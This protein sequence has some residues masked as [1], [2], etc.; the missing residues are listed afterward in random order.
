MR[1]HRLAIFVSLNIALL[2]SSVIHA[3]ES[4]KATASFSVPEAKQ[5]AACDQRYFYAVENS[6]IA[7]YDRFSGKRL[8]VST[9]KA[10]H[11][12]S[13]LLWNGNLICAHSNYPAVPEKSEIKSLDLKT[14]QLFTLK[15]FG[16]YGGSLTWVLKKDDSW[17]CNFAH[18]GKQNARTFLVQFDDKWN[19]IRRWQYPEELISQLGEYSLSGAVWLDEELVATGHDAKELYRLRIPSKGST[20]EYVNKAAIP[21]TGQGIA[22]DPSSTPN[23]PRL[24]GIDR[25]NRKVIFAKLNQQ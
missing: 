23:N 1:K 25:A 17:W 14:M 9:G 8:A 13:A 5:A 10:K 4:W 18:Y 19:E 15:D 21:F 2:L 16:N 6:S 24:V 22:V 20:I 3:E 12:N 11:L 7:K